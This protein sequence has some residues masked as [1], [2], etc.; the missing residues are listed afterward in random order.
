MLNQYAL[1]HYRKAQNMRRGFVV[2]DHDEY[3]IHVKSMYAYIV[4]D[5]LLNSGDQK[6]KNALRM[7]AELYK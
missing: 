2:Y 3:V 4:Y 1:K 7:Y 6:V 5:G